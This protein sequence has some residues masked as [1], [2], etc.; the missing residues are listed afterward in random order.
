MD[1]DGEAGIGLGQGQ[2]EERMVWEVRGVLQKPAHS[3]VTLHC[4]FCHGAKV[5]FWRL[6]WTCV[7][8]NLIMQALL[9]IITITTNVY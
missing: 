4:R 5:Y 9:L 2:S 1:G 3:T 6:S 7:S 8:Q